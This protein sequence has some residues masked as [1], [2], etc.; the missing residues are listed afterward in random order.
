MTTL[1]SKRSPCRLLFSTDVDQLVELR[2]CQRTFNGAC[3]CTALG[4]LGYSLSVLRPFDCRFYLVCVS[5]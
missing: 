4:N 5:L 3:T 1:L 2:A